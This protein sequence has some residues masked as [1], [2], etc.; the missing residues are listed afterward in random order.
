MGGSSKLE[1]RL[2]QAGKDPTS[3]P[4]LMGQP[5]FFACFL[6]VMCVSCLFYRAFRADCPSV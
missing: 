3:P 5:V 1:Q 2:C 4:T 6:S